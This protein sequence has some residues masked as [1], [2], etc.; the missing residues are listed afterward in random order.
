MSTGHLEDTLK[1]CLLVRKILLKKTLFHDSV[2]PSKCCN[3]NKVLHK[4]IIYCFIGPNLEIVRKKN[5]HKFLQDKLYLQ[6]LEITWA[7]S[8]NLCFLDLDDEVTMF[9]W[10]DFKSKCY[11]QTES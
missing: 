8:F 1:K 3:H 11:D 2:L 6:Q 4:I 5:Q 7:V 10:D 9:E